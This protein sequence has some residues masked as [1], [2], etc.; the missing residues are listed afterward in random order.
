MIDDDDVCM[1]IAD[2]YVKRVKEERRK[3]ME[4]IEKEI[5]E[6]KKEEVSFK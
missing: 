4:R 6:E 2:T 3:E 5:L 1:F